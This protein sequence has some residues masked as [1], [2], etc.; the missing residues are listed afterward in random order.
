MCTMR[1]AMWKN[2]TNFFCA[3]KASHGFPWRNIEKINKH[4]SARVLLAHRC[5]TRCRL[6]ARYSTVLCSARCVAVAT[7][8]MFPPSVASCWWTQRRAMA[9]FFAAFQ[10]EKCRIL[11]ACILAELILG[12]ANGIWCSFSR[13][14]KAIYSRNLLSIL[15]IHNSLASSTRRGPNPPSQYGAARWMVNEKYFFDFLIKTCP[16]TWCCSVFREYVERCFNSS[17]SKF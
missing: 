4:N 17:P 2:W 9:S 3:A 16:P 7:F 10:R 5:P 13:S 12:V 8:D 6:S 1:W 14:I 15:I 11:P